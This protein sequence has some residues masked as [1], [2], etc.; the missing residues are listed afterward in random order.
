MGF[1]FSPND[2]DLDIKCSLEMQH[3]NLIQ[4]P[5]LSLC[6]KNVT[7]PQA[8]LKYTITQARDLYYIHF[9][10]KKSIVRDRLKS[11]LS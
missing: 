2:T 8:I 7:Y 10:K 3:L 4:K 9:E 6:Y 5:N 11:S 1:F